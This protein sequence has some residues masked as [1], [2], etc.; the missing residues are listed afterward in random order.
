IISNAFAVDIE[1]L[2]ASWMPSRP[3]FPTRSVE[4]NATERLDSKHAGMTEALHRTL[5]ALNVSKS[6]VTSYSPFSRANR[7]VTMDAQ[8]VSPN[9]PTNQ[10]FSLKDTIITTTNTDNSDID[11]GGSSI[12][13]AYKEQKQHGRGDLTEAVYETLKDFQGVCIPRNKA[14]GYDEIVLV[15]VDIVGAPMEVDTLSHE[16]RLKIADSL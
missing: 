5:P 14:A 15:V 6:T 13:G 3:K 2:V 1:Q 9:H 11:D 16:E 4:L 8:T 10:V 12:Y 7:G